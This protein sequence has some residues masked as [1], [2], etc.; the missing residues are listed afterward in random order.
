MS[1]IAKRSTGFGFGSKVHGERKNESPSPDS[2]KLP[3]EFELKR[4]GDMY[5]FRCSWKAYK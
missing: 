2:Y 1:T 3:S 5:S 4:K